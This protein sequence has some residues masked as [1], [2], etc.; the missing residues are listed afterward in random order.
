[1]AI[2]RGNGN[3]R[4]TEVSISDPLARAIVPRGEDNAGELDLSRLTDNE[5]NEIIKAYQSGLVDVRL[6]A[7]SLG[8]DVTALAATLK[9]LVQT[10][11]EISAA[12]GSSV[13]ITHTQD[14]AAGR[15]EIIMGN[16]EHAQRGKLTR[17][18]TGD[19]DMTPFYIIGVAIVIGIIVIAVLV[20]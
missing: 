11:E 4:D 14:S 7:S 18:Q 12:E 19:R 8:V 16:T 9:T 13:T 1:M 20:R 15:T 3:D 17:S 5:R 10:T 2:E 6:R